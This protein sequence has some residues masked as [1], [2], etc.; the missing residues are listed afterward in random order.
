M[1]KITADELTLFKYL[2]QNRITPAACQ[3]PWQKWFYLRFVKSVLMKS[4]S[5]SAH[6]SKGF[7]FQLQFSNK[8]HFPEKYLTASIHEQDR[9]LFRVRLW[10][11][12][13]L[14]LLGKHSRQ[15]SNSKWVSSSPKF[16]CFVLF[17]EGSI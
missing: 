2:G 6:F 5:N 10:H 11:V 8:N 9:S 17:Y 16:V 12:L 3:N 7:W 15:K 13:W 4:Q 14:Y 1:S